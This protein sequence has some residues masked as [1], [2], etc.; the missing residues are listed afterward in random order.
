VSGEAISVKPRRGP[1]TERCQ[2]GFDGGRTGNNRSVSEP[3]TPDRLHRKAARGRDE[4]TPALVISGVTVVIAVAVGLVLAVV[5]A[6][7]FFV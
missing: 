5:L 6:L 4:A 1:R 7:Y 2:P 3:E